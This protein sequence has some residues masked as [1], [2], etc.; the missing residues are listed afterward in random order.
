M[1]SKVLITGGT[2]FI[3]SKL[4]EHPYFSNALFIGRSKPNGVRNFVK[5]KLLVNENFEE[6]LQSKDTVI[7]LA[8]IAHSNKVNKIQG[9]SELNTDFPIYLA[10][11]AAYSGVKR[12]IFISTIKVLGDETDDNKKFDLNSK[13]CP[14]DEYARSKADAEKGLIKLAAK[15]SMQLVIIRPPLVVGTG[16]KGN[17]EMVLRF[18]KLGIPL[19]FSGIDNKRS[20][21]YLTD[22]TDLI[23]HCIIDDRVANKIIM[24]KSGA[25]KNTAELLHDL[26]RMEN[27]NLKLF[28]LPSLLLKSLLMLFGG[29]KLVKKIFGSL[30]I[31]GSSLEKETGWEPK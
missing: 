13:Y 11:K 10:S 12:F 17:L 19:P 21:L 22:L 18:A 30:E 8:G 15:S 2:G 9:I 28:W 20:I 16:A 26:A 23:R 25:D 27:Q 31:D 3:G 29:R 7:H 5:K 6:E 1:T 4:I 24:P 14:K